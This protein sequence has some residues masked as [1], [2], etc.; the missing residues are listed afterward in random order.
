MT[1]QT[2]AGLAPAEQPNTELQPG[3]EGQAPEAGVLGNDAQPEAPVGEPE[4]QEQPKQTPPHRTPQ[5]RFSEMS[6]RISEA[7][8]T[9]AYWR[10]VAEGKIQ[11][12]QHQPQQQAPQPQQ[13]APSGGAEPDPAL[14]PL[15]E[16]DA[17]YIRDLARFEARR[18]HAALQQQSAKQTEFEQR[19]AQ[20]INAFET[21]AASGFDEGVEFLRFI[22]N[23]PDLA[24]AV[25]ES[26]YAPVVAEYFAHNPDH[27]AQVARMPPT[28]RA[29]ELDRIGSTVTARLQTQA[30]PAPR[31]QQAPATPPVQPSPTL[32]GR[33]V[34]PTPDISRMSF[35]DF[36]QAFRAG[37]FQ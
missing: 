21:T 36:E 28:R 12:Q 4:P 5:Y 26:G 3:A 1:D 10:G 17:Q 37:K 33:G 35:S 14:Y 27:W 9:A 7:E 24:D 16:L 2:P 15:G 8:Q 30:Q 6:R 11:P 29:V 32:S 19:K 31:Q 34:A 13:Q 23:T 18:E 20:F 22:G 25:V